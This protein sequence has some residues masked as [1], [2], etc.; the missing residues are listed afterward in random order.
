MRGLGTSHIAIPDLI[1]CGVFVALMWHL[2]SAPRDGK[3]SRAVAVISAFAVASVV[4]I[5][6]API[7]FDI[8]LSEAGFK[9]LALLGLFLAVGLLRWSYAKSESD[10]GPAMMPHDAP[11]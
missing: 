5:G 7:W 1:V 10:S 8:N 3:L 9:E 2:K 11:K 6:L 4:V